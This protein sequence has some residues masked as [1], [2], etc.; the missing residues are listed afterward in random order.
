MVVLM[1]RNVEASVSVIRK[2]VRIAAV[3][4]VID[5]KEKPL[6]MQIIL[7]KSRG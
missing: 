1:P 7:D 4:A 3:A 5:I 2:T 6:K